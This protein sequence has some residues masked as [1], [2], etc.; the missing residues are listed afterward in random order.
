MATGKIKHVYAGPKNKETGEMEDE[1]VYV[2]QEYPRTL[3]HPEFKGWPKEGK[4]VHDDAELAKALADG[5][6][7]NPAELGEFTCP[8]QEQIQAKET[9][10]FEAR[11]AKAA[12]KQGGK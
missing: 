6:V 12:A 7:R 8:S 5:W 3:Y 1:P 2:H 10:A 11:R 4:P 9:A